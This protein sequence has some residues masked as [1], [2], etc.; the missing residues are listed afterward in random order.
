MQKRP[1]KIFA[2]LVLAGSICQSSAQLVIPSDSTSFIAV[3]QYSLPEGPAKLFEDSHGNM[4]ISINGK[5]GLI[6]LVKDKTVE[7]LVKEFIADAILGVDGDIWYMGNNKISSV[8]F[9]GTKADLNLN[10]LF[11]K[12]NRPGNFTASGYPL[13]YRDR[14]GSIW[15]ADAPFRVGAEMKSLPNQKINEIST[16]FP[17]P[18]TTDPFGNMWGLIP[19]DNKLWTVGAISHEASDKWTVFDTKSGFP[20]GEWNAVVSDIEGIIWVAG[21]TGLYYFDPF[22]YERGW[23]E[24]P[25]TDKYP[26]GAVSHLTLSASGHALLYLQSGEI[27]EVNVDEKYLPVIKLIKTEGLPKLS[28]NALYTDKAGRIWVEVNNRLYRQDKKEA[29]WQPLTSMPYG[30]HDD[31]GVELNGKIYIP[32][33]GAYHGLPA[34]S[35]NFDCLLI[36]DIQNDRWEIS[37][38]MS[39]NRRYCN[40]GLLDGKIYVIGGYNKTSENSDKMWNDLATNTVEIYD[41]VKKIWSAGPS[42]DVPRAETFTC[43]ISGRLYVFGS[44]GEGVFKTLSIAPGEKQWRLE[45]AAPYPVFQTDG[46]VIKNKAYMMAGGVGLIMY[47]PLTQTWEKSFP[48]VLGSKAPLSSALVAYNGKIWVISG[49]QIDD[50]T[51]VSIYDPDE[52]KWTYGPSFP[53]STK[54]TDGIEV[55]GHLYVFGG[56]TLSKNRNR[57]VFWDAIRI[58]K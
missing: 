34:R 7:P 37:P 40:V 57:Y 30:N 33:G 5:N 32:G 13:F 20:A 50:E 12:E 31:F 56:S 3:N 19:L 44:S 6:G 42:L 9:S 25:A 18:L 10:S 45:P 53:Y 39:I 52:N 4:I 8:G 26:G 51:Q 41:P 28:I 23:Y 16:R 48:Q 38:S 29:V 24:F 55:N 27:F 1:Q 58:L 14:L 2:A 17:L 47:D 36:Y 35:T 46:C 49:R 11:F 15:L 21:Y 54:W 43:S 22:K